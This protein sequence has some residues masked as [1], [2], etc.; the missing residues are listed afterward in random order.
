M[1][2]NFETYGYLNNYWD[3]IFV[4]FIN[5]HLLFY[6]NIVYKNIQ[7]QIRQKIKDILRISS[8]SVLAIVF[9]FVVVVFFQIFSWLI[10]DFLFKK[11]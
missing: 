4:S 11:V 1:S 10:K 5:T 7:A 2:L 6:K 9:C 3:N 8:A